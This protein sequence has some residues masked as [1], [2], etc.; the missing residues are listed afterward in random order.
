MD[1]RGEGVEDPDLDVAALEPDRVGQRIAIDRGVRHRGVNEPDVDMGK[2]RLP[3]DGPLGLAQRLALDVLD[4]PLELALGDRLIGPFAFLAVRR[5]EPLDQLAGDPDDDLR[6]SKPGHLLGLLQGDGAVVDDRGDIGDRAGLH[7]GQALTL[8]TD[9]PDRAVTRVVDLED[10][11]LGELGADI[12]RR[13]R[14]QAL[15]LIPL[16]DP[17]P[18]GHQAVAAR[19][20]RTAPSASAS[21]SRRVPLPC[22]ISGRPPPRPSI[23]CI[24]SRTRS[25]AATPRWTRSSLTVTNSCGSSAA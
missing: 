23:A 4:K 3:R 1:E 5:R 13:A 9:A 18:E 16:P 6:G 21:P 20:A 24:A 7:V 15:I 17:A 10:E 22:A 2:T 19:A 14:G 25:P 11:C 12:E 8:P